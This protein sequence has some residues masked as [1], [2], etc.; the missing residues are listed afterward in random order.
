M[1]NKRIQKLKD[2]KA[3]RRLILGSSISSSDPM[4][5]EALACMG[6]D[7]LWV[8][9]EHTPLDKEEVFSHI[10]SVQGKNTSVW[11]RVPWNDPVLVKPILD[12]GPDGIIFPMISSRAEAEHASRSVSYPPKGCRGYGPLRANSYGTEKNYIEEARKNLLCFVMIETEQGVKNIDD[13]CASEDIDG[14]LLG[15]MDLSFSLG[16]PGQTD[17][18]V[19]VDAVKKV[20]QA[21]KKKNLFVG[22]CAP[23][24]EKNREMY[25][26]AGVDVYLASGDVSMLCSYAKKMIE[27]FRA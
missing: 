17:S 18:P 5:S 22:C 14:I 10:C 25:I 20:C 11:V 1:D 6:F 19:F 15:G 21:A 2:M 26:D 24:D 27:K 3:E 13:I 7:V 8:D 12:M 4:I 23:D 9:M 16:C